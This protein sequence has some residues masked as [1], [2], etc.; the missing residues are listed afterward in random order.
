MGFTTS[1]TRNHQ[2]PQRQPVASRLATWDEV[3]QLVG[4]MGE[5]GAGIFEIAGED[6]GQN[7]ERIREYMDRL[8]ALAVDTGVPVTYGMFSMRRA[9]DCWQPYLD[10]TDETAAAGGRMFLQVAQPGAECGPVLPNQYALRPVAELA[11]AQ[12]DE[13]TRRERSGP[14]ES[15]LPAQTG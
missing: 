10:L 14:A 15:R 11:C 5:M 6:T 13:V 8:K 1:R 4:T 9:P 3:R 12:E 2:T 7:P